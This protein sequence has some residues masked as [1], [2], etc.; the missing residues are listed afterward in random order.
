MNRHSETAPDV[1]FPCFKFAGQLRGLRSGTPI[2]ATLDSGLEVTGRPFFSHLRLRSPLPFPRTFHRIVP[3]FLPAF[4]TSGRLEP[5]F[6]SFF[7]GPVIPPR[8]V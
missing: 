4:G 2:R 8:P 3:P 7:V 6:G 5:L 1:S